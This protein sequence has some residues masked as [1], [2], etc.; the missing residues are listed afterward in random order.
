MHK[1]KIRGLFVTHDIRN[2]GASRSLQLLL[3]N[4]QNVSIDLVTKKMLIKED[5]SI[6]EI[7]SKFGPYIDKVLQFY[8]PFDYCYKYKPDATW[9]LLLFKLANRLMWTLTK[10]RFYNFV[11]QGNYDFIHLNSLVLHPIIKPGQPFFIHIRDIY[12]GSNDT[13]LLNVQKARGVIFIDNATKD[14]FRSI[15]LR[16]SIILNNPFNMT[17]VAEFDINQLM[18][19][20]PYVEKRVIFSIIGAVTE[21]KGV[22]FI[23]RNFMKLKSDTATLLVVGSGDTNG[24][25]YVTK[26]KKY[27]MKDSRIVFLGEVEKIE[28]IYAISDYILRGE[29]YQCIGRT[30]YEGLYAG[31]H[32]IIPADKNQ[33]TSMFEYDKF[34]NMIFSYPPRNDAALLLLFERLSNVKVTER[35]FCSNVN[36]Y[37]QEFHRFVTKSC[38]E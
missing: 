18:W 3:N 20:K 8:L 7:K 28:Q 11:K 19:L 33:L 29:E 1:Y 25:A 4:Y 9:K 17:S 27:A 2:Y 6:E 10:N 24:E 35:V 37:V 32:V 15:S 30:I 26:C 16:N 36:A 31:C 13:A 23:I 34:K 12:D 21:K 14:P 5:A 38:N 22:D